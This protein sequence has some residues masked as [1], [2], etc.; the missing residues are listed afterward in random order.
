MVRLLLVLLVI[1]P[2]AHADYSDREDVRTF[3]SDMSKNHGFDEAEL[4]TLLAGVKHRADI[5]ER[6]SKPAETVWTWGR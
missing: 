2:V 1:S 3:V 5:I 4:Q 6:I